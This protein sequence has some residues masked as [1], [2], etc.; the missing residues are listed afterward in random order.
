MH[1]GK[2]KFN[3]SLTH[4]LVMDIIWG[5]LVAIYYSLLLFIAVWFGHFLIIAI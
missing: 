5:L 4:A 2:Q 1:A 3:K